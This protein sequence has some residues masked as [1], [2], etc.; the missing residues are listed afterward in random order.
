MRLTLFFAWAAALGLVGSAAALTP[1]FD[2]VLGEWT[3]PDVLDLGAQAAPGGGG[4][5]MYVTWDVSNLYVGLARDSSDRYLGDTANDNDSF[6]VAVDVDGVGG[7]GAGQG[8][9][10]RMDFGGSMLP[11][12]IYYFAGGAGWYEWSVWNAGGWWDWQ[13]WNNAGTY[14][15]WQDP[16]PDDELSIPLANIGGSEAVTVWAWMTREGNGYV[17][18]SW[19]SGA[20]GDEPNPVMGDGIQVPEPATLL[21]L[22]AGLLGLRRKRA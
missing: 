21:L 18:A 4:Y 8:G 12:V 10:G 2:G 11:D 17:E 9:Y 3:G 13:G 5:N 19:P 15:G 7:S 6:F 20:T 22:G 16:N 1:T 14:Y